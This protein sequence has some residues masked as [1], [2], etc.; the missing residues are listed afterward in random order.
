MWRPDIVWFGE[1]LP[2]AVLAAAF[3]AARRADLMLV[4][5]TSGL[6]QPAASLATKRATRA[7]VVEINPEQ[8][9][10]TPLVDRSVRAR[11]SDVLPEL[12]A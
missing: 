11:A 9:A 10:L 5:G 4:V 12:A 7:Y 8:T 6:V 3:D 2:Q 1:A